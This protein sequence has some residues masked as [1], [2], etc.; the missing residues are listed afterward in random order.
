MNKY[1][2]YN[3]LKENAK[4]LIIVDLRDSTAFSYGHI[5]NAINLKPSEVE[6]FVKS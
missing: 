5:P 1:A 6:A 4:E 2:T 3:M